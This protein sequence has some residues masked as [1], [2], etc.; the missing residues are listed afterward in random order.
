MPLASRQHVASIDVLVD[1]SPLDPAIRNN[2]LEVRVKDNLALPGTAQV[3][4]ADPML[5]T[6]DSH[7]LQL[8][9]DLEIKA[10]AIGDSAP[11]TIFKGEVVAIEPEF[12]EESCVISV[13][14]L[15]YSHRLRQNRGSR[16]FQ[17]MKATDMVRKVLSEVGLQAG[18]V[19]STSV[20]HKYFHQGAETDW[21]FLQRLAIDN[22]CEVVA[23]GKTI[24]F[25]EAGA[26]SGT[27]VRLTYGQNLLAFRPRLSQ[28]QQPE[29][30][31]VRGWDPVS[32]KELVGTASNG[33]AHAEIGKRLA[34][35]L[36][37]TPGPKV[38]LADR[39][40]QDQSDARRL[41]GSHLNRL[42]DSFVEAEGTAL[43]AP[44]VKAGAK[45]KI[46][47]VGTTFSGTYVVTSALHV[48]K[49]GTG[50]RTQ[51]TI[52]GRSPR[53]LLDLMR[54]PEKREWGKSFVV[55]V[56]TNNNDP[57]QMGRVKVKLPA[58][59][60]DHESFWARVLTHSA[61]PGG[62]GIFMLPQPDEEVVVGFENGDAQRPY[63]LGSVF[64]GKD[65]PGA[66][67]LQ[68]RDG[69]FAMKSD[70]KIWMKS[71][72]DI[73]ITSDK[74]MVVTISKD[75]T[76][77]EGGNYTNEATGNTKVKAQ[78]INI[79]AGGSLT[80]KGVSVTVEASASLSLKGATASL[81]ASGPLQLKGATISI[82]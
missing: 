38:L 26:G 57:D 70:K 67:L 78:Q 61:G 5:E 66:D 77:K 56:V 52:S 41:A 54:A 69:S 73:E 24:H 31:T 3:R 51:F 28:V 59:G 79:E 20:V 11:R 36:R 76:E 16:T 80:I 43:G 2:L 1:G 68:S 15:E 71:T 50:Y 10:G 19:K 33:T 25:R 58:L 12:N 48:Y 17:Q 74:N 62:R 49:G 21:D 7:P 40:V 63:V 72:E 4:L 45:V 53:T 32:K 65:K 30:V 64:N 37:T 34:D 44:L 81:Q 14:A 9:K 60:N 46:E 42:A 13:R 55:G 39:T 27:P 18:T 35:V 6:V 29:E 75:L 23:Q 47:E 82:G 22:D 8:G